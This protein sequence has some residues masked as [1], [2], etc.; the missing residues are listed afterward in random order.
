MTVIACA[1]DPG[2]EAVRA[3]VARPVLGVFR[4]AVAAAMARAERFGVIAI[5]EASKARHA[6]AL[7]AMGVGA[8]LASEVAMNVSMD[9]LLDAETARAGLIAVVALWESGRA[10][11]RAAA[12][13]GVPYQYSMI[14]WAV[15]VGYAV[16]GDIPSPATLIGAAVIIAAGLYIFLRERALGR[17]EPDAPPPVP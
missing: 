15:M 9:D 7:R 1:S 5:V 8:R 4:C 17:Q 13:G 11:E 12:S 3:A 16:C 2:I 10:R 6:A 14:I